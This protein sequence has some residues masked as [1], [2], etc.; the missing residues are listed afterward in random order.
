MIGALVCTVPRLGDEGQSIL[1]I[2]SLLTP[3]IFY[4]LGLLQGKNARTL[5]SVGLLLHI[6]SMA[7]RGMIVGSIPLTEKHDNI[8]FFA[9]ATALVYLGATWRVRRPQLEL[10]AL[11]LVSAILVIAVMFEPIN[12]I[13]PFL[14]SPWFLLHM[15]LYFSGYAFFGVAMCSGI[16]Y[17]ILREVEYEALQYTLSMFGWV[18]FSISLVVGSIWFFTA[19]GTYW[20]W[21]SRELWTTLMWFYYGVYMHA[22]YIKG[23]SGRPAAIIGLLGFPV[24]LFTYF[25]IGTIIPSPPTPF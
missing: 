3:A 20:L 2:F 24:A 9:F 4:I 13:S 8:S 22:R 18:L 21:T 11:S 6:V 14:R 25:G 1:T 10:W 17:L 5:F 23:L 7:W 12:T 19:Y 16:L 15:L